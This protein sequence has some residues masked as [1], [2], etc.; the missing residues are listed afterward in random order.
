VS[1][2]LSIVTLG[3][4]DVGRATAFYTSLG[5]DRSSASVDGVVTFLR[6]PGSVLA[7][8]SSSD[9]AD[10]AGISAE[11]TGFR[12][13]SL[14]MNLRSDDELN[15]TFDAWVAAGAAPVKEPH[16]VFF[17]ATSYVTDLDGH[18]WELAY[19]RDFPF[20]EDGRLD[21]PG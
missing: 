21:L 10:D 18:L 5:F 19:N 17:G 12:H 4:A 13:V 20:T 9:L 8:F 14:A 6:T 3:V 16:E 2:L 11:G 15:A 7:L 1:A